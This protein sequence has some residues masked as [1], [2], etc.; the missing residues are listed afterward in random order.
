MGMWEKFGQPFQN[1]NHIPK[2]PNTPRNRVLGA[3]LGN[4]GGNGDIGDIHTNPKKEHGTRAQALH[5]ARRGLPFQ[6]AGPGTVKKGNSQT[7]AP[8]HGQR[9]QGAA[10][11][12]PV[13]GTLRWEL[14]PCTLVPVVLELDAGGVLTWQAGQFDEHVQALCSEDG[15]RIRAFLSTLPGHRW[16]SWRQGA[17]DLA[18]QWEA[19]QDTQ[20][21]GQRHD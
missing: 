9:A 4:N 18:D 11:K 16:E 8:P 6:T 15:P 13:P 3:P 1:R 2:I 7:P 5:S 12:A 21:R 20:Q 19:S 14:L 17:L 10:G